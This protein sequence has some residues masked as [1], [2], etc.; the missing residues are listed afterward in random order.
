MLRKLLLFVLCI[1]LGYGIYVAVTQG[2]MIFGN[3]IKPYSALVEGNENIDNKVATLERLNTVTYAQTEN[4]LR[5]AKREFSD[6]KNEYDTL[7]A[8]ASVAEIAEANKR[9]QYLLD[10]LW[11]KIGTYA[12]ADNVK[13][14]ITPS[15]TQAIVDFDVTGEYISVVN[16]IYDLEN[17]TDLNFNVDNIIMQG[18]SSDT[19]TKAT[20]TVTG[21]NVITAEE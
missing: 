14:K 5:G 17:D 15:D 3:E 13:I 21:V 20:F 12:N 18:G 9:E 10:Y 8:S 11:M 6:R 1:F 19:V 7:A 16:F 4:R 2:V